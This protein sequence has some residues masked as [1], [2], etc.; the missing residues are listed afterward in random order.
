MTLTETKT[1]LAT[2]ASV[3]PRALMPE[4][5]EMTVNVWYQLLQDIP[6][7]MAKTAVAGWVTTSKYPPTIAD[8]REMLTTQAVT[9]TPE[10]SWTRLLCAI[11]KYGYTRPDEAAAALGDLWP[12]ATDW[13][14]YCRI[15]E[16]DLPNEK[17]RYLR[18]ITNKQQRDKNLAQMP[19]PIRAMLAGIGQGR[20]EAENE[21]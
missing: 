16:D 12:G 5:T 2:M 4:V 13:S 11:S 3:Y 17:A 20:L 9:E 21:D 7:N 6:Y 8:I 19:A 14:Y 18:M 10:Q 1:I 15:M